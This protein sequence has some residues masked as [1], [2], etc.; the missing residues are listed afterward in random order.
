MSK[1]HNGGPEFPY[2]FHFPEQDGNPGGI[3]LGMSLRDYFAAAALTN[4]L[5]QWYR[6]AVRGGIPLDE[7]Y[8]H[9]ARQAYAVADA[10]LA[11][12][13]KGTQ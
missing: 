7:R 12:R 1:P 11:E 4:G 9:A 5:P 13:A 3:N 8:A 2:A 10:M 6:G